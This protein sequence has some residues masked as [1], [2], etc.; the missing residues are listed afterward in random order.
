MNTKEA[1]EK[2]GCSEKTVREYCNNGMIPLA[3]K[4][5]GKWYVPDEMLGLPPVTLNRAVYLLTCLEEHVLPAVNKYWNEEKLSDALVYLSDMRFIIG[6]EG[7]ASLEEA[8]RK[9]RVS[10]LG[11]KLIDSGEGCNEIEAGG[12]LELKAGI[13]SGLPSALVSVSGTAKTKHTK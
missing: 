8:A 1:A 7:H 12:G 11:K 9:C 10:K 13:E 5:S 4:V 2:W 6:Y 3:E